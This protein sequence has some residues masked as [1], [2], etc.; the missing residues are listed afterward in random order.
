[1]IDKTQFP[2]RVPYVDV[3]LRDS[4]VLGFTGCNRFGSTFQATSTTLKIGPLQRTKIA[5]ANGMS[6]E[7]EFI[8]ALEAAD[9]CKIDGKNLTLLRGSTELVT[10]GWGD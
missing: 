1:M 8:T 5:C 6:V 10:L 2:R 3:N 9:S 7:N 4:H